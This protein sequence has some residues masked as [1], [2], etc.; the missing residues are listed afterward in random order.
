M[1]L[2]GPA[3]NVAFCPIKRW[4]L[5]LEVWVGLPGRQRCRRENQETRETYT[6]IKKNNFPLNRWEW[7]GIVYTPVVSPSK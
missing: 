6:P 5:E 4:Q 3:K 7:A 1:L 2:I